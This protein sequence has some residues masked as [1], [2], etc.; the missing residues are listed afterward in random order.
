MPRIGQHIGPFCLEKRITS[1]P[2][3]S[4]FY[5]AKPEGTRNL[6]AAAIKCLNL[7]HQNEDKL[8]EQ[9]GTFNYLQKLQ[10]RNIPPLYQHYTGQFA[11][12]RKWVDGCTLAQLVQAQKIGKFDLNLATILDILFQVSQAL[13]YLHEQVPVLFHGRLNTEHVLLGK[14]GMVYVIGLH[15]QRT[16]NTPEYSSPEQASEAFV[17]WRTDLWALGALLIHLVLKEPL[18]TGRP[19]AILSAK[20]GNAIHWI[21]RACTQHPILK[22]F[23]VK[24][25]HPAAGNRFSS[26]EQLLRGFRGLQ[27]RC[28][29]TSQR[30]I[31]A[32]IAYNIVQDNS[33][34]PPLTTKIPPTPFAPKDPS[35]DGILPADGPLIEPNEIDLTET[36]EPEVPEPHIEHPEHTSPEIPM[37]PTLKTVKTFEPKLP[38]PD[39]TEVD[40]SSWFLDVTQ[41]KLRNNIPDSL[42]TR[43]IAL[44]MIIL[45]AFMLLYA[46]LTRL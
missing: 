30:V 8:Q 39:R 26:F 28:P 24:T 5:A 38:H 17:D 41:E 21:K 31:I 9:E 29:E 36:F 13:S 3:H 10:H 25:L 45:N 43:K 11:I 34:I 19:D 4:L 12:A 15:S 18:Y 22:G 35:F 42:N 1:S 6:S 23:L 14:D 16:D 44:G 2:T 33:L 40:T 27:K 7:D 46:I 32:E 37:I 20:E